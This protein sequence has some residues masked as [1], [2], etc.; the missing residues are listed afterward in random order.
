ME[1]DEREAESL[2][3]IL[4]EHR[5]RLDPR[6]MALGGFMRD[7]DRV[8]KPVTQEEL[9]EA[10]GVTR[11][12]YAKLEGRVDVK[13]SAG[14]VS[15]LAD[16]FMLDGAERTA[17]FQAAIPALRTPLRLDHRRVLHQLGRPRAALADR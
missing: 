12:W 3:A 1:S 9:A 7:P 4:R 5:R 2:A 15:R 10:V 14:L 17:L 8:G 11:A 16:I 6:M 13:A